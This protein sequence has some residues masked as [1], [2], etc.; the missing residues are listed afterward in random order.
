MI[1][2]AWLS[3]ERVRH[4]IVKVL[5]NQRAAV[6]ATHELPKRQRGGLLKVEDEDALLQ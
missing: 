3:G 5:L 1:A 2:K 6:H 4:G